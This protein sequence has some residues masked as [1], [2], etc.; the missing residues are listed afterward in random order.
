MCLCSISVVTDS[1]N[2]LRQ[3]ATMRGNELGVIVDGGLGGEDLEVESAR[4]FAKLVP[5]DG[6]PIPRTLPAS[7]GSV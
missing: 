1:L 4:R 5:A 3:I 6:L 2:D 7:L